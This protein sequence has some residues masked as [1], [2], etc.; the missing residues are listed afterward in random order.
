MTTEVVTFHDKLPYKK[1]D[2]VKIYPKGY[3]YVITDIKNGNRLSLA[4]FEDS[5]FKLVSNIRLKLLKLLWPVL[6]H[7]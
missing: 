7:F 3:Q 6:K 1:W 5:E 2:K 4:R